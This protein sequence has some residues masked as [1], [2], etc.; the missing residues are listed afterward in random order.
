MKRF[1]YILILLFTSIQFVEATTYQTKGNMKGW[2]SWKNSAN[3]KN[4]EKPKIPLK[5][6]DKVIISEGDSILFDE[7][8]SSLDISYPG[9]HGEVY[10]IIKG[11][12]FTK[13]AVNLYYNSHVKINNGGKFLIDADLWL[14]YSVQ[15]DIKQ[16]GYM[17]V[18]GTMDAPWAAAQ[19]DLNINVGGTLQMPEKNN[20]LEKGK[21]N[22]KGTWD[23]S[24][25]NFP[26]D[27]TL[28][29]ELKS[30]NV[31]LNN[32]IAKF[33]WITATET[34]NDYFTIEQSTDLQSWESIH[35]EQG[36]G[37]SSAELYYS[38]E[39]ELNKIGIYYFRLKQT[40]YDGKFTYSKV[41]SVKNTK[42]PKMQ[43]PKA[44]VSNGSIIIKNTY[45][46][47][48]I[49]N[50]QG[51]LVGQYSNTKVISDFKGQGVFIFVFDN[52]YKQK[53]HI[54]F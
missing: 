41:V 46:N 26:S 52:K 36:A 54:N 15:L 43:Q 45:H 47:L 22:N 30:F 23:K 19:T 34:N 38:A 9:L 21:F 2:R 25:P 20:K 33:S 44:V 37:N 49:F 5:A 53:I 31:N 1:T 10:L 35:T 39:K 48:Q 13:K 18:S 11:T 51:R 14:A 27:E 28:P 12:L 24:L 6:G 17:G 4:G 3:W 29:I 42:L 16:G 7:T 8:Q 40:D 32:S 50:M